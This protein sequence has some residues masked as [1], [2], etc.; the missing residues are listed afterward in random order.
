MLRQ[1]LGNILRLIFKATLVNDAYIVDH[2]WLVKK[3][4]YCVCV[5]QSVVKYDDA[6]VKEMRYFV[7]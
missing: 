5:F 1:K 7:K 6:L 3:N 4:T 2:L